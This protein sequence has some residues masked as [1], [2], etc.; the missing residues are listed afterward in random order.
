V[1]FVKSVAPSP[2]SSP[3]GTSQREHPN[4]QPRADAGTPQDDVRGTQPT[5]PR[6]FSFWREELKRAWSDVRGGHLT[7]LRLGLSVGIGL[8]VGCL[9]V[10]GLHLPILIFIA[11]RFRL[12]GFVAYIA[13]N[14]SNPF[15]AP[16]LMTAEV[17]V[18]AWIL[19]GHM[20]H[21]AENVS[22]GEALR[23]FPKF[24]LVGA[25]VVGAALGIVGTF[26]FT[27]GTKLK[28]SIFGE[29][30]I[31]PPYRL[32]KSAPPWVVAVEKVASRYAS[33][34]APTPRERT[35]F[36]YVR[37]KLVMDPVAKLIVDVLGDADG[38]LGEVVDV[39]TGR[40]QLPILLLELGHASRA[41][42]FDW[43]ERKIEEAA[44]AAKR[45]EPLDATFFRADA[46]KADW[47]QA[48]TVL[49]IDVLHYFKPDE[50][51]AILGRALD[52]VRPGGRILIREADT[53]R[54]FRS[55]ITLLEERFFTAIRFNRG[56]RVQ[57]RPA[58]EFVEAMEM[59]GFTT[60]V[61]PAWGKTPFSNVLIVGERSIDP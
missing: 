49:I 27:I 21:L 55:T 43:D 12:D 6:P 34:T 30:T 39:G 10:F 60:K 61:I 13:A 38:G 57:F 4:N 14:I 28:R 47:G 5:A 2:P 41:R 23:A 56:E 19:Q 11:L 26:G 25:P 36:H 35:E 50:Q 3:D 20:L 40:G 59:R 51:D 48:D 44:D 37:I 17:Q 8:F 54:G 1:G 24:L 32:P 33:P 53:E 31:R 46:R 29:G 15:F 9:P 18:G 16:F 45:G 58:R 7:P 52:A 42:A 22:V